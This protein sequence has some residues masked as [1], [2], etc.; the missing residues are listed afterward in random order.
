MT[1]GAVSSLFRPET[2]A[3][4]LAR[5]QLLEASDFDGEL[6]DGYFYAEDDSGNRVIYGDALHDSTTSATEVAEWLGVTGPDAHLP[7]EVG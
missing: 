1:A 2:F 6:W 7:S 3:R 5:V 4:V